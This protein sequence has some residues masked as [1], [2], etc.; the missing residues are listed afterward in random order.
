MQANSRRKRSKRNS[1]THP[2]VELPLAEW[3]SAAVPKFFAIFHA[4]AAS[5]NIFSYSYNSFQDS[6]ATFGTKFRSRHLKYPVLDTVPVELPSWNSPWP[7]GAVPWHF[8]LFMPV[9]AVICLFCISCTFL[10]IYF[11]TLW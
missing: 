2:I 1:H 4:F 3:G 7:R 6:Q 10:A 8:A 11:C 5:S 9:P